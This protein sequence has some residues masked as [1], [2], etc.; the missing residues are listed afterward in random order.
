MSK[1]HINRLM[2]IWSA[3]IQEGT[4]PFSNCKHLQA[5]ID[6]IKVGDIP[7]QSFSCKYKGAVTDRNHA[8]QNKEL[9]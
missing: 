4:S 8:I 9:L 1:G 5:H 6:A 7:W 2:E 3:N